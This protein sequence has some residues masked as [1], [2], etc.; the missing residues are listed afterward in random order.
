MKK[1]VAR[2]NIEHYRKLLADE[3]D[4]AKRQRLLRLLAEEEAKL[5]ALSDPPKK[6]KRR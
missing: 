1:F 2:L 3:A 6:E 5:V 4:D